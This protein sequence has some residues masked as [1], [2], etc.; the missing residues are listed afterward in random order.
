[1]DSNPDLE[2]AERILNANK[3]LFPELESSDIVSHSV[4]FRPTR[5]GGVRLET[6]SHSKGRLIHNYGHGG[7]GYQC[8]WGCAHQVVKELR[9]K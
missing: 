6:Q 4:G 1:M 3:S 9:Q 2:T 7:M 5:K 8:S